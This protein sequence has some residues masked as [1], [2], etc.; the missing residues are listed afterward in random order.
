MKR[1]V[2]FLATGGFLLELTAASSAAQSLGDLARAE[3]EKREKEGK[4]PSK[5]YSTD[6]ALALKA[7]AHQKVPTLTA[8]SQDGR[9]VQ[10]TPDQETDVIFMATWCPVSKRLKDILNDPRTRPYV[11]KRKLIFLFEHS[12]WPTMEAKVMKTAKQNN[13]SQEDVAIEIAEM[14]QKSGSSRVYDPSFL[15]NLPGQIYFCP[16][17][18]EV[19]GFPDV[20]TVHGYTGTGLSWLVEERSMPEELAQKV[21]DDYDPDKHKS[22][23]K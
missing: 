4:Q 17:P 1:R 5:V 22:S 12:E 23:E 11:A 2:F 8:E 9:S 6:D 19:D 15:D 20:L 16:V 10:V 14:K 13:Y 3:K 21:H 7:K 18:D